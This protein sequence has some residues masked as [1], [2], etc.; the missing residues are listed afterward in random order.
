MAV[1][2]GSADGGVATAPASLFEQVTGGHFAEID[3]S[4]RLLQGY[5]ARIDRLGHIYRM[6]ML[7]SVLL[8]ILVAPFIVW[9][10]YRPGFSAGIWA[11]M[12]LGHLVLL[13]FVGVCPLALVGWFLG[14]HVRARGGWQALLA[15]FLPLC[16]LGATYALIR[17]SE[18]GAPGHWS[19]TAMMAALTGA[20]WPVGT[21]VFGLVT[22]LIYTRIQRDRRRRHAKDTI[23]VNLAEVLRLARPLYWDDPEQKRS[24]IGLLEEVAVC[25]EEGLC[26]LLPVGDSVTDVW[27]AT[28]LRR[29][30]TFL[31]SLKRHVCMPGKG[32]LKAFVRQVAADLECALQGRWG[33]MANGEP[34]EDLKVT[35]MARWT[36]IA[37]VAFTAGLPIVVFW[38]ARRL[39]I[40]PLDAKQASY[41]AVGVLVWALLSVLIY[42]DPLLRQKLGILRKAAQDLLPGGK[43]KEP[44]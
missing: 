22:G 35:R 26:R 11:L 17:M 15:L 19:Y 2:E 29:K 9:L 1:R 36:G 24:I 34:P 23:V 28:S 40:L 39:D 18:G 20:W 6:L 31:R 38:S 44:S 33:D 32:S 30:A 14:W 4:G 42:A 5:K 21:L 43:G 25:A 3:S 12:L 37:Q 27:L 16:L 41:V 13:V 7:V 10:M 8:G